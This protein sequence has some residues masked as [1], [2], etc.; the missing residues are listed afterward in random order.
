[1]QLSQTYS[2]TAIKVIFFALTIFMLPGYIMSAFNPLK[3]QHSESIDSLPPR[4]TYSQECD[5]SVKN[6]YVKDMPEDSS[7]RSNLANIILFTD[8]TSNF[9]F[10]NSP[11]IPGVSQSTTWSL[12]VTDKFSDAHA[13]I[14]FT[15][16]EGNA[17]TIVVDYIAPKIE[18]IP[19]TS[20][21]GKVNAGGI[22]FRDFILINKSPQSTLIVD[23]IALT[24]ENSPFKV[25]GFEKFSQVKPLDTLNFRLTFSAL[26]A[27][28][29][30][31]SIGVGNN[32]V[33]GFRSAISAE[34]ISPV[35]EVED[36]YFDN[37]AIGDSSEMSISIYNR[38]LVN[39]I[40][41]GYRA[42][43][44]GSYRTSL[45]AITASK[46]LIIL[47][48]SSFRFIVKFKPV[49]EEKYLDSLIFISNATTFDSVCNVTAIGVKP[50][51]IANS[52]DWGRCR[53][54]RQK[55]PAGP[56]PGG[57]NIV[58]LRNT[59]TIPVIIYH[60]N[61]INSNRGEAFE[62]EDTAFQNIV[63]DPGKFS[64]I[65]VQFHPKEFGEHELILQYENSIGS[66]TETRLKGIGVVP[67][68]ET[69]NVDFG[70]S[71]VNSLLDPKNKRIIIKNKIWAYNDLLQVT[72][73]VVAGIGNEISEDITKYGTQGF[74]YD[75]TEIKLPKTLYPGQTIEFDAF[76]VAKKTGPA[77]GELK[78][79]SDALT[80]T[81]T[82]FTGFGI[83]QGIRASGGSASACL[84]D[85]ARI[86]C[87]VENYG[88]ERIRIDS[89]RFE[90]NESY[91]EFDDLR[92]ADGFD[93]DIGEK[94]DIVLL[95]HPIIP[96]NYSNKL[97]VFN[98][99]INMSLVNADIKGIAIYTERF[100][101]ISEKIGN[102]NPK[103]DNNLRVALNLEDGDD[104]KDLKLKDLEVEC[105]F[106]KDILH[107]GSVIISDT[108]SGKFSVENMQVDYDL[109][110]IKFTLRALGSEIF[111]KS[112]ELL[113]FDFHT[114]MPV[115]QD[116]SDEGVINITLKPK[117]TGCV[118]FNCRNYLN[119]KLD[120]E[121][122]EKL[123]W[124]DGRENSDTL[125]IRPNP[126]DGRNIKI[127][128]SVGIPGDCNVAF[129]DLRGELV[130]SAF[131]G[132]L[133]R[134]IY[135]IQFDPSFLSKNIYFC[136]LK[137][138]KGYSRII[139]LN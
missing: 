30:N 132:S 97:L 123:Q 33:F 64:V 35:I 52:Y 131:K 102:L 24:S 71:I 114:K 29:Y 91:I 119:I 50:G 37:I 17:D 83:I 115:S 53:I 61:I 8:K 103:I 138:R 70:I 127:V 13:E 101:N 21:F 78:I 85:T 1:M 106:P 74:K 124:I 82:T 14:A 46:P 139:F 59:G 77:L 47:P 104:I 125:S 18:I 27:G 96:K 45:P 118:E 90:S 79:E 76:F 107:P 49:N 108:L 65:P 67:V 95:F 54:D 93:L 3:Y 69:S 122:T 68:I 58:I 136:I 116:V 60:E 63:I 28:L 134:G 110:H 36:G 31:D 42:F 25:V 81:S 38:G 89:L 88:S 57:N 130:Q 2:S 117:N 99:T 94:R 39:L 43:V 10:R 126:A 120:H 22:V 16:M 133:Q 129:Y 121:I 98:N 34:V 62:Y 109:G 41:T 73:L 111:Y 56:Y 12:E 137:T 72:D 84:G 32:C 87:Q 92:L 55:Y 80:E 15:D 128:F 5:G 4:I 66:H 113:T 100:I 75:K 44:T 9:N 51:L 7:S 135:E 19:E 26:K 112:G 11:F 86:V 20:N 40:I 105:S 6:G 48:D 23:R